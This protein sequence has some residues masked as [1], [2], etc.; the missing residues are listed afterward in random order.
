MLWGRGEGLNAYL[1]GLQVLHVQWWGDGSVH[2]YLVS[3]CYMCYGGSGIRAKCISIWCPGAT[4]VM[5]GRG[6]GD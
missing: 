5:V 2:I 1:S 6:G 3:R 4:C